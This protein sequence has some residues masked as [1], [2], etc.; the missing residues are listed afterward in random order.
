MSNKIWI[1]EYLEKV[2]NN[3]HEGGGLVVVSS[4]LEQAKFD[5]KA[6]KDIE[7]SDEDWSNALAGKTDLP[8]R[9]IVFPDS[10]CC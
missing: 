1:F 7:V 8:K 2:S 4:N 9:I 6:Q 5:V 10:G 3:Y